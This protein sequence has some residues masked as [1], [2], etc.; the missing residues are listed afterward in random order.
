MAVI[1][2]LLTY[3]LVTVSKQQQQQQQEILLTLLALTCQVQRKLYLKKSLFKF[4]SPEEGVCPQFATKIGK[5]HCS[6]NG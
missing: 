3:L 4:C 1:T 2:A 5:I 6:Y